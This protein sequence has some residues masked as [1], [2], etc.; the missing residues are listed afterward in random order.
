[1][2]LLKKN[3]YP[4]LVIVVVTIGLLHFFTPGY[5]IFYHD[6]YRRLSY[7]PIA[8][9][10]I[11]FGV[12]G[13]LSLAALTSIAFIPH[14]LIFIGRG[15]E[16]YLSELTEIILYL[17]AGL[18]IGMIA[19]KESKLRE[20]YRNMSERLKKS[21]R[22]LHNETELL[23]EVEEQLRLSQKLSTLGQ[24]SA[25]LA[26]EI[27]NPLGSI[28]G[29]AEILLDDYPAG[30]PKREFVDIINTE[31]K[32]L[33]H[34]VN[35]VLNIFRGNQNIDSN[36]K[37]E[38]LAKVITRVAGL[39]GGKLNTKKV[40]FSTRGIEHVGDFQIAGEKISQIF[41]NI[42]L[43]ALDAVDKGGSIEMRIHKE[44]EG[45]YVEIEDSGPGIPA[46]DRE[47]VFEPFF[48]GK[49]DGTGLGLFISR[50]I[51]EGYSG[52]ITI[53]ESGK[54]TCFEVFLPEYSNEQSIHKIEE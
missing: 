41:I 29:A 24:V 51:A 26:H 3:R 2:E 8:L 23:L 50:K 21:Y 31:T 11:W 44:P 40:N 12:K 39:M 36:V 27:K 30:H 10:G 45:V 17:A 35:E 32:R 34:S 9:G 20:K 6:T 18:L 19:G 48:T 1:M 38:S 13:G 53:K 22:R 54:G 42:I 4:I 7:F 25:S 52:R 49:E 15:P 5:L 28:K 47:K 46:L 43:N 16:T 37:E 14:L 33:D